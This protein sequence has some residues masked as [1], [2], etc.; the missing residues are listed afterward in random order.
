MALVVIGVLVWN[1]STK[2]QTSSKP[3]SF[4]EFMTSVDGGQIDRVT[5]TGN[6]IT[7][8]DKSGENFRTYAPPQFEGLANKLLER[9]VVVSA[10][11][12]ATSPWA[13]LL[14]SWAPSL[15]MIGF[16]LCFMHQ[17]PRGRHKA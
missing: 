12:P 11:E 3:L 17:L 10:R 2:F 6:E 4:S 5:I 8:V 1:F 7:G 13:A 15:L 14:Y 9:N 16:W